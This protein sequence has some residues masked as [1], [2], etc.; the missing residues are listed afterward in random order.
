MAEIGAFGLIVLGIGKAIEV[1][2]IE[3]TGG[4]ISFLP[5]SVIMTFVM[6]NT[7][8]AY[9]GRSCVAR[10]DK[11]VDDSYQSLKL[12]VKDEKPGKLHDL[13][14]LWYTL[15]SHDRWIARLKTDYLKYH[16][17]FKGRFLP[18]AVARRVE[19]AVERL[20]KGYDAAQGSDNVPDRMKKIALR[21]SST[22][23]ALLNFQIAGRAQ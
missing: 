22:L 12:R 18:S 20:R 19:R 9:N 21:R 16:Q 15:S 17:M 1:T 23:D 6:G 8:E 13:Y 5:V 4:V 10:R 11:R 14:R 3:R 2:F 7:W